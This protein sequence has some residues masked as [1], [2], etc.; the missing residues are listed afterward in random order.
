MLWEKQ[1]IAA[2]CVKELNAVE[3]DKGDIS[4]EVRDQGRSAGVEE[5][6]AEQEL[7]GLEEGEDAMTDEEGVE[8]KGEAGTTDWRVRAVPI[9][10]PT[11]KRKGRT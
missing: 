2:S 6:C 7:N 11:A 8:G 1:H 9:N 5:S 4:E 3:E 10:K